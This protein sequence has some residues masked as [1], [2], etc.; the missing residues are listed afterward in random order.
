V[1][2]VGN[3]KPTTD[4]ELVLNALDEEAPE[5]PLLPPVHRPDNATSVRISSVRWG[6]TV[7][8]GNYESARLDAEAVV[9]TDGEAGS[10][11]EQLMDWVDDHLP[12]SDAEGHRAYAERNRLKNELQVLEQRKAAAEAEWQ[13]IATFLKKNGIPVPPHTIEEIPF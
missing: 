7:N 6:R 2:T 1:S 8:L 13:R 10:T 5:P 12:L 4:A 9:F 11:L 3:H